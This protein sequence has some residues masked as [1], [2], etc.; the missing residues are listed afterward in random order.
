[1]KWSAWLRLF[2]LASYLGGSAMLSLVGIRISAEVAPDAVQRLYGVEWL[3]DRLKV[4]ATVEKQRPRLWLF[5]WIAM[6]V[7]FLLQVIAVV[8]ARS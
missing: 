1:M 3:F 6:N 7:G 8:L 5:G 4:A 2:G